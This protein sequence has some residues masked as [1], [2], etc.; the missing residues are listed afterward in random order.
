MAEIGFSSGVDLRSP[1]SDDR[2]AYKT[3]IES[4]YATLRE[5]IVSGAL[6]PD[7]R[8]RIDGLKQTFG[9]SASTV[10]E[11]L[12]RLASETLVVSESQRGF[13]VSSLSL[14]DFREVAHLRALLE[15]HAVRF[16]I[17]T[18]DDEWEASVVAA[19]HKLSKVEEQMKAD[20]DQHA[21]QWEARNSDFH[22]ALIAGW[23]GKWLLY[24]R[25]MLLSQSSRYL[26][27]AVTTTAAKRDVHAEHKAI[28]NAVLDRN[29]DLA[30]ELLKHHILST[31]DYMA[32][33]L[34]EAPGGG[35]R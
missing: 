23:D 27:F 16:S 12:T 6:K 28:F 35:S 24:F 13:R 30:A 5:Q 21:R 34:E 10:R 22:H 3:A 9:V 29:A 7:E 25:N 32:D 4:I 17:E 1:G 20:P 26:R 33:V 2:K 19:Y 8:L 31:V 11:A 15:G 14:A 18:G